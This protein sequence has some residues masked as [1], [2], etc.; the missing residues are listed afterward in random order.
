M[1]KSAFDLNH[2]QTNIESKIIASLERV[3][4]AFRVLLWN[5]SKELV[6]SPLQVQVLI[7]LLHHPDDRCKVSYLADEF[8]M[9]KATISDAIKALEQKLLIEKYYDPQ[10]TRSY[11]IYLTNKGKGLAKRT[12]LFAQ[13]IQLP[14]EAMNQKDKENLLASMINIIHHLNNVG[15]IS[16]QR[17]CL[18]C[19]FYK[20][21]E[22]GQSHFCNLMNK[23]L[24]TAELQ[25][26]C[27][28]HNE[29]Q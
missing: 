8:N 5:E 15:I 7:F 4:Q 27:K 29:I 25:V 20:T 6:L 24:T 1:S 26:D 9:S 10:D 14:I 17:M 2:Q 21:S 19:Q 18:T 22:I 28:E 16:I 3:S 11:K 13:Q 23:P 12:S